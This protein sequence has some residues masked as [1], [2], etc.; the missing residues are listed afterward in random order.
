MCQSDTNPAGAL[1]T[2]N[3]SALAMVLPGHHVQL[4]FKKNTSYSELM[5]LE[6]LEN[7]GI[8]DLGECRG[9][10]SMILCNRNW[11]DETPASRTFSFYITEQY[12][13]DA[14]KAVL[15]VELFDT[16]KVLD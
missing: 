6:Q 4:V 13:F 11:K 14:F 10:M 16:I 15:P 12:D 9:S 3:S 5:N 7:E 8:I 1:H 2:Q